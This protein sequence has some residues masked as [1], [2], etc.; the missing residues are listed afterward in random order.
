VLKEQTSSGNF[1]KQFFDDDEM[2]VNEHSRITIQTCS[3]SKLS[4]VN[5]LNPSE[6]DFP[7]T[8]V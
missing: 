1:R 3:S 8:A 2:I 7:I 5:S 6:R 4:I